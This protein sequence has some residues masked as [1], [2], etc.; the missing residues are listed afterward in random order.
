MALSARLLSSISCFTPSQI[1]GQSMG[2]RVQFDG[3]AALREV[4]DFLTGQ[5]LKAPILQHLCDV[6]SERSGDAR[7]SIVPCR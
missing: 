3:N 6:E 5:Q 4:G 7:Q 2:V 1:V